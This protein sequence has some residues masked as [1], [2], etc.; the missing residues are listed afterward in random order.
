MASRFQLPCSRMNSTL[1]QH[2]DALTQQN[3]T[4]PNEEKN[5][6]K[7]CPALSTPI[8]NYIDTMRVFNE[9]KK[10]GFTVE[11]SDVILQL[12]KENL[13]HQIGHLQEDILDV[14]TFENEMY[15]F[16]AAQSEIRVEIKTSREADLRMMENEKSILENL[17]NEETD[18]L[19]K[20]LILTRNDSQVL[21]NDQISENTLLQRTI[22]RRIQDLNNRISTEING[23]I[24][25]DIE[26]LRWH[27]TSR[28]LMAVLVLVF[29]IMSGVSIS[30]KRNRED[31]PQEIILRTLE[32]E[33][34]E[35]TEDEEP[36]QEVGLE[37]LALER[38]AGK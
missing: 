36:E 5:A 31:S 14:N 28:G 11:Q 25:S 20:D 38:K 7:S 33:E 9:L 23:D 6:H 37:K 26:G 30:K 12:I 3:T 32:P 34:D 29:A 13:S 15:L 24:K 2:P 21:I 22:K 19:N 4:Q 10:L 18:D 17:I 27:T 16:E 35:T 1:V 8:H